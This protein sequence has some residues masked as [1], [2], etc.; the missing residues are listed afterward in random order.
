[1]SCYEWEQGSLKIP[2]AEWVRV[3]RDL[4]AAW[5][6]IMQE[7][8]TLAQ[9]LHAHLTEARKGKRNFDFMAAAKAWADARRP[10]GRFISEDE[11]D[12]L[13]AAD[14]AWRLAL[15]H[16]DNLNRWVLQHPKKKDVPFAKSTT[17]HFGDVPLCAWEGSVRLDDKTRELHWSVSENNH[18]VERA[19]EQPMGRALA[20]ILH[21]VCWTRDSGG[22]FVGNNE[23]SRESRDEGGGS[24]FV[25][26]RY[27]PRGDI[28]RGLNW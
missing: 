1:M 27:G 24:N 26:K 22:V 17:R 4:I 2:S 9:Q 23:Y 7:R 5:N 18:A 12:G 3:R 10:R 15:E 14:E 6:G 19:W 16:K 25:T 8:L 28:R 13:N 21:S 20:R 11:L